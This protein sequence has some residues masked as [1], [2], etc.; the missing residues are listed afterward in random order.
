VYSKYAISALFILEIKGRK[1][2]EIEKKG[3]ENISF[4]AKF[5]IVNCA[6]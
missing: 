4:L 6:F 2:K 5:L 3:F 1:K